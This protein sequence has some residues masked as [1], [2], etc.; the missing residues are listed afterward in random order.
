MCVRRHLKTCDFSLSVQMLEYLLFC[1]YTRTEDQ[2]N[3]EV[4]DGIKAKVED[5]AT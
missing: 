3:P 4:F 1:G 2:T 5:E